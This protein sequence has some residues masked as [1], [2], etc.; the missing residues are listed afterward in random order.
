MT[1][2]DWVT[3]ANRLCRSLDL[4]F[5]SALK[6]VWIRPSC[7]D[8]TNLVRLHGPLK[9]VEGSEIEKLSCYP[10]SWDYA[11]TSSVF[12]SVWSGLFLSV[13]RVLKD[14]GDSLRLRVRI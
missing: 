4:V 13:P 7:F 14:S 12:T 2:K 5:R 6:R 11:E 3:H 1:L 10:S 8:L 9:A